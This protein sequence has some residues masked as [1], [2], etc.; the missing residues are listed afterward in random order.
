[1]MGSS[2][3]AA[4]ARVVC[5]VHCERMISLSSNDDDMP[6][7]GVCHRLGNSVAFVVSPEPEPS[8]AVARV[9]FG[10]G[11]IAPVNDRQAALIFEQ[12]EWHHELIRKRV[13]SSRPVRVSEY[14]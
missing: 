11:C 6:R 2:I 4:P 5:K 1:M 14:V 13:S 3:S 12:I 8:D 9:R 10:C 7:I